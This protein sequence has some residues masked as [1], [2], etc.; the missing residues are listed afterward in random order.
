MVY[1]HSPSIRFVVV[2]VLLLLH[3]D[4]TS[5]SVVYSFS[6]CVYKETK[7]EADSP[8]RTMSHERR[9]TT[10]RRRQVWCNSEAHF[11]SSFCFSHAQQTCVCCLSFSQFTSVKVKF[12][13]FLT[14]W[15]DEQQQQ[16]KPGDQIKKTNQT[17]KKKKNLQ[18][19]FVAVWFQGHV[20]YCTMM[21]D[22]TTAPVRI[23]SLSRPCPEI[24]HYSCCLLLLALPVRCC[25]LPR[26]AVASV[27]FSNGQ[28]HTPAT[29][30]FIFTLLG[31]LCVVVG[32]VLKNAAPSSSL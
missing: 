26:A 12:V 9:M 21:P 24:V 18:L 25:S 7:R 8:T 23:P 29:H 11:L 5:G 1:P 27:I 28:Q 19:D 10:A 17:K 14:S 31:V 16:Q 2:V 20:L 22:V 6:L 30:L 13:L 32:W 4:S 15:R 3:D